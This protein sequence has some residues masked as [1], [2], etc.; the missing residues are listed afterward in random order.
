[1]PLIS[2][3]YRPGLVRDTTNYTN[4]GGFYECDKVRFRSGS[5]EKIGGWLKFG[6]FELIGVC[7]QMFNYVTSFSDNILWL[8]T[9]EKLYLE[10]GGN[11][12][13]VTPIRA[14]FATPDTDNCISTTN[15]STIVTFTITSHGGQ[16]GD[17]VQISGVAGDP[18]GVT[19]A[20]INTNHEIIQVDANNFTITVTTAATSTTTSQGGTAIV[21]EFE[22]YPGP[23]LDTFG[24]GWG[25]GSWGANPWGTG[26][27][28]PVT[29]FQR[30]WWYDSFDNDTVMN[31]RNGAI[32]YWELDN[33]FINRAVLL[34]SLLGASDVPDAAMQILVSQNDKHLLAFGCQPFGEA[35]GEF[36]PL[37]IRFASQDDPVMWT[38][39]VTNS[40]GFIRLSNGDRIKRALRTRQEILVWTESTLVSLQFLGTT[41]VFGV[42]ELADNIS[43]F[44]PR[45]VSTMNNVTYWMGVDKFYIYDGR[46]NTLPCPIRD[47]IFKDINYDQSVQIVSGTNEGWNEIWWF[48]PSKNSNTNDRYVIYNFAEQVWYF[49]NLERTAWLDSPLRQ[50]PQ[51]VGGEYVYDH[52]RGVNDDILPM[53]SFITSSDFDLVTDTGAGE[54]FML[55]KRIIPDVSFNGS[56]AATPTLNMTLKPRNFP[57]SEYESEPDLPVIETTVDRYTNQVFIRARARQMGFKISSDALDVQW[58]LGT[59]RL[60]GRSDGRR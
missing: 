42:Q 23:V 18:G 28:T 60:E 9:N 1:M 51:A 14:S 32:Y 26:S 2:L 13:N 58:Q 5:A 55:T 10:V 57:G 29:I 52:E 33:T 39:L 12:I 36:D 20:Q 19:D 41:D 44:G 4:K 38:P 34:S 43:L 21:V 50:Y 53:S 49:G 17:Y 25:A 59:P 7:R 54:Q 27:I 22:I 45:A 47:Y 30:D 56:T 11:L 6:V 48:Y 16:T 35:P 31:I 15:G 40:A 37:L 8:G 24:Y 46:V 3:K